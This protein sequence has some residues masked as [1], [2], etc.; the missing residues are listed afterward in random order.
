MFF[1]E[2]KLNFFDE[3]EFRTPKQLRA[4]KA[5]NDIQDSIE[6]LS[7]SGDLADLTSRKLSDRSGYSLGAIFHH[8]KKFDDVFVYIFLKR[9]EKA[10]LNVAEIINQ[11]PTDK[12]VDILLTSVMNSFIDEL[13]APNPKALLFVLRQFLKRTNYPQLIN[14]HSDMLINPWINATLRDKTNTFVKLNEKELKLRF[15]AIQAVIR[16]PFFEEDAL[17]RTEE[18]KVIIMHVGIQLLSR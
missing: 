13:S 2:L 14:V 7:R 4:Q 17:A 10:Y 11:H 15:R 12:P 8:F 5:L 6:K 16:S 3:F 9:R 18:H 1:M